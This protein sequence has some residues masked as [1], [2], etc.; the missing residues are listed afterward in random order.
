MRSLC[1]SLYVRVGGGGGV[2][3]LLPRDINQPSRSKEPLNAT[4]SRIMIAAHLKALRQKAEIRPPFEV[5]RGFRVRKT[6]DMN[7]KQWHL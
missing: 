5:K 2:T 6:R 7:M 4:L 1:C 3:F